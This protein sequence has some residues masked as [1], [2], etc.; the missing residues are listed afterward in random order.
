MTTKNGNYLK[1]LTYGYNI[2][3]TGY[4]EVELESIIPYQ[5]LVFT[6]SWVVIDNFNPR[7][8]CYGLN[9]VA[10]RWRSQSGSSVVDLIPSP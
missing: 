8:G 2:M 10:W 4:V 9:Y 1:P 6:I 3:S 5:W 7:P